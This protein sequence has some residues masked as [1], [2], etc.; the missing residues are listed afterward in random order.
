MVQL[1]HLQT[2]ITA[3][4]APISPFKSPQ[5]SI[6][7]RRGRA[8]TA[9]AMA[10]LRSLEGFEPWAITHAPIGGIDN[11]RRI[12]ELRVATAAAACAVIQLELDTAGAG[13]VKGSDRK[14]ELQEGGLK[15]GVL[16]A[17]N[18]ACHSPLQQTLPW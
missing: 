15:L 17:S 2:P 18:S 5:P 6:P 12:A 1:V 11:A 7:L 16:Q 9:E 8:A 14:R 10:W 13:L 3:A 4:I